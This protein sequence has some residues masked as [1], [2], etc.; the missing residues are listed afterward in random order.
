MT[1]DE[2]CFYVASDYTYRSDG[3]HLIGDSWRVMRRPMEGDCDDYLMTVFWH[4]SGENLPRFLWN[5]LITHKYEVHRVKTMSGAYH[6]VGCFGGQWFDNWM[7]R[8]R[9]K[10]TFFTN[11]DHTYL[12]RYYAPKIAYSLL[13]GLFVQ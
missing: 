9:D 5:L 7:Y 13:V 2:A 12:R 6:V 11:P 4:L 3:R 8:P 1:L 10:G